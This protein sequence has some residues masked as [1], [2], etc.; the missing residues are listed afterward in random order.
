MYENLTLEELKAKAEELKNILGSYDRV[1]N[2]VPLGPVR[3][4]YA[5]ALVMANN[6]ASK[7]ELSEYLKDLKVE[8]QS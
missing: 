8:G 5:W 6:G 2:S 7:E 4:L 1:I 3:S